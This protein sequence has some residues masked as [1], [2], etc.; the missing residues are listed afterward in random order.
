MRA[1]D[2]T[3]GAAAMPRCAVTAKAATPKSDATMRRCDGC[4]FGRMA[5]VVEKDKAGVET[6][7]NVCECH[8]A[9]PTRSGFPMVRLDDFCACHVD[10]KTYERTFAGLVNYN[11]LTL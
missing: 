11:E 8:V 10:A 6:R 5:I 1:K 3:G 7:R 9:R 4:L 2:K